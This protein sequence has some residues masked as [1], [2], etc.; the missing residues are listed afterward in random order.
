MISKALIGFSLISAMACFGQRISTSP[1]H[2]DETFLKKA[3][4]GG[5]AE[6]QFGELAQKNAS[7]SAV[8]Q[9]GERMMTDHTKMGDEVKS[10]A[11]SKGV[12]LPSQMEAKERAEY[13]RLSKKTGAEF[14]RDYMSM[15]VKDHMQDIQEFQNEANNG[16]DP[17]VKALA[18]K[19]LPTLREHLRMAENAE[20][21]VGAGR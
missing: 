20:K 4:A 16:Q 21:Q 10:L 11:G 9:F 12:T 6:V 17:D 7:S 1:G 14:D 18:A 19:A 8:K 5:M 3:A 13:D 15:M 2:S